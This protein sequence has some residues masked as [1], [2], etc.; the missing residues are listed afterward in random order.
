MRLVGSLESNG[1]A[2]TS[3]KSVISDYHRFQSLPRK[4]FYRSLAVTADVSPPASLKL[5]VIT[6]AEEDYQQVII[7]PPRKLLGV[8]LRFK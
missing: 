5:L 6:E 7:C 2:Y 3:E 8:F 4:I 1:N